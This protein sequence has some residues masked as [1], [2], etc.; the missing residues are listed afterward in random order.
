MTIVEQ[1]PDILEK[2]RNGTFSFQLDFYEQGVER[3]IVFTEESNFVKATCT[4]RTNWIPNPS[5]IFMEKAEVQTM[6]ENMYNNF[7]AF[8]EVLCSDLINDP[9]LN[10]WKK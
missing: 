4:S 1:V 6:F 5:T 2:V 10:D 3:L 7:L 8:S 9:L